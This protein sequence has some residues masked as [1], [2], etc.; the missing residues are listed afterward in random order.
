MNKTLQI[1]VGLIVL[2]AVAAG[3]FYAGTI[4]AQQ[5]QTA[6]RAAQLAN[7]QGQNPN[8][9]IDNADGNAAR[10]QPGGR[11]GNQDGGRNAG[12]GGGGTF[13]QIDEIDGDTLIVTTRN[14]NQIKVLVTGTTLIEKYASVSATDL[15]IGETLVI[16]GS[17]NEDGSITARSLQVAPAGR[18]G[19]NRQGGSENDQ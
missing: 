5:Q 15:E 17:K 9:N 12:Q 2:I 1:I 16:S 19:G 18:M 8:L 13:G 6:N 3:S 10:N 4:Y 7:R 14:G 11:L